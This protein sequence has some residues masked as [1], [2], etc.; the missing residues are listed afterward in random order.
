MPE[1]RRTRA[2]LTGTSFANNTTGAITAEY[3]RELT[4]ASLGSYASIYNIGGD[5][6]P[7]TQAVTTATTATLD[8]DSAT[9]GGNG[10]EDTDAS[11]Y[12]S[13][14]DVAND[15]IRMHDAGTY[16]VTLNMAFSQ[17]INSSVEWTVSVATNTD[18]AGIVL[19]NYKIKRVL[20]T[21]TDVGSLSITG[22]ITTTHSSQTDVTVRLSHDNGSTNTLSLE[23]ANLT[24]VRVG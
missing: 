20:A 17:S 23:Y 14:A 12:G 4:E 24:V 2:Y 15:R 11:T 16:A 9:T 19:S 22:L 21:N 7:A 1:T 8:W 3:V 10:P 13:D 5:T 18:A 6:T